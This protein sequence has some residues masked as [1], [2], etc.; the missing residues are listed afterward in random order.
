VGG[1]W[2][3]LLAL[4]MVVLGMLSSVLVS[5]G[6]RRAVLAVCLC[7][8]LAGL[9]RAGRPLA[10]DDAATA[11]PRSCQLEAWH[12]QAG[13]DRAW[14]FAPACGL[15]PGWELDADL[16]LLQPREPVRSALGLAVKWVPAAGHLDT[17]AGPLDLGLKLASSHQRLAA[18][19][20]QAGQSSVL[21]LAS[22]Q[23]GPAWAWHANLGLAHQHS[24]GQTAGLLNLALAW[25]PHPRAQLFAEVQANSRRE[26]FG[27]TVKSTG[28]RWWLRPDTLGL[29]L[30]AS[31]ESGVGST[32]WTLGLGWYGLGG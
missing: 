9:A 27:G 11:A 15:A 5:Q 21:A 25:T 13:S 2:S 10:T 32:L 1:G 19:G 6:F 12:E 4:F 8:G 31:R 17:R 22:G 7:A 30:T 16:T 14:V 23:A 26:W 20:W 24:V 18:G 3:A 28:A 29:D